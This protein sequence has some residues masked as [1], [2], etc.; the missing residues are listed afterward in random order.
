MNIKRVVV[1]SLEEN[2]YIV[3]KNNKCII[4]DPGDEA[5]KIISYITCEVVG[6]LITHYHFDH[7]GALNELKEKY[8]LQENKYNIDGFNFEVIE[9][10]GH[11]SDSKTYYF[12][13][14][15]I[16][17]VGDFLFKDG[18][19]RM[20]LPTGSVND[21]KK[22]LDNIFTYPSNTIIYPGHGDKSTLGQ[23]LINRLSF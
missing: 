5:D 14:D 22:S 19:G 3:E 20:D 16:M 21:M 18:I 2:C 9:T 10:P 8:N 4:I 12:K 23:E 13:D 7:I 17:F 15:N 11:T 1:G 6:I